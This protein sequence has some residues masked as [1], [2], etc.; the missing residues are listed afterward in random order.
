MNKNINSNKA[1][2]VKT[3]IEAS[4]ITD[5]TYI[6]PIEPVINIGNATF[7]YKGDVSFISGPPKAGKSSISALMLATALSNS[8]P[9]N[10]DSLQI[11]S[12][13]SNGAYVI[14]IDTEQPPAFTKRQL[15]TVK[16]LIGIKDQPSNFLVFNLR[17]YNYDQ[18]KQ[19]VFALFDKYPD[20]H[21]WIIDGITDLVKGV[22][23]EAEANQLIGD[24]MA[25][26]SRNNTCIVGMIHENR[27]ATG[28]LRGH[29]GAEAERKSGGVISIGKDREKKVH[30][31]EPKYIRGSADFDRIYFRWDKSANRFAQCDENEVAY[32]KVLEDRTARKEDD[33]KTLATACLQKPCLKKVLLE[34][35]QMHAPRKTSELV[36]IKTARRYHDK[37]LDL[38]YAIVDPDGL[39]HLAESYEI[40]T[41][42][43]QV[44]TGQLFG[45]IHETVRTHI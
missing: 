28:N 3:F 23:E 8:L 33:L 30:W 43:P 21:L 41:L 4:Q 9:A 27:G 40:P 5:R 44:K 6:P 12:T 13:Y 15:E 31:I 24:L 26:T 38:G 18:R 19:I 29:I 10:T 2:D 37:M 42:V 34:L 32:M 45:Q 35:I 36:H 20:A 25:M 14:Y 39:Y 17:Q 22:N 1:F 11:R 7:A 16:G